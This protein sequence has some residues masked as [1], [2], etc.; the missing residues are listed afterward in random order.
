VFWSSATETTIVF[1]MFLEEMKL[2]SVEL[3][4]ID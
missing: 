3:Q 4:L 2:N 1:E